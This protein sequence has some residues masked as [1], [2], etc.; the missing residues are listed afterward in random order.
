VPGPTPPTDTEQTGPVD[1][2]GDGVLAEED[3]DDLDPRAWRHGGLW[4]GDVVVGPDTDLC[5]SYCTL[6]VLGDIT[7]EYTTLQDLS[8]LW[9]ITSVGDDLWIESNPDLESLAGLE[10]LTHVGDEMTVASNAM[11]ADLL[12]LANLD[13]VA[14]DLEIRSN[15]RSRASTTWA[16]WAASCAST[17]TTR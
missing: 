9:C 14:D 5:D 8:A 3:C 16:T 10:Q 12:P 2:D 4:Q 11:L 1:R 7:V 15:N 17:T 6:D 13:S